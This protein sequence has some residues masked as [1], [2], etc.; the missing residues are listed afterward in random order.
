MLLVKKEK[1]VNLLEGKKE[2]QKF[3]EIPSPVVP[4]RRS[5]AGW[6]PKSMNRWSVGVGRRYQ[7]TMRKA[8][9]R[10]LSRRRV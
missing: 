8:S 10:T 4:S 7:V 6:T 1:R 9:F 5:S 2:D 3:L